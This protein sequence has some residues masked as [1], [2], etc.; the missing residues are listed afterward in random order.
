MPAHEFS[1]CLDRDSA[2]SCSFDDPNGCKQTA[3]ERVGN[4]Q[5]V[6]LDCPDMK[7]LATFVW[8]DDGTAW[9]GSFQV[10]GKQVPA[11]MGMRISAKYVGPCAQAEVRRRPGGK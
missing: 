2:S 3:L 5:K 7:G 4:T 11:G 8:A 9:S 10:E 6:R 1:N